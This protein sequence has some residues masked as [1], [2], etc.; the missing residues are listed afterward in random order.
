[1]KNLISLILFCGLHFCLNA[2]LNLQQE[3][4]KQIIS[5]DYDTS[6]IKEEDIDD[7][8]LSYAWYFLWKSKV[9]KD[10][11]V[12]INEIKDILSVFE[13]HE[14]K[15]GQ[16]LALMQVGVLYWK[17]GDLK[18]STEAYSETI[19]Y[20]LKQ[21]TVFEKDFFF[22]KITQART[23]RVT[24]FLE[25]KQ[26]DK[27][28]EDVFETEKLLEQI[29]TPLL[30]IN[31]LKN[32]AQLNSMLRNHKESIRI[33]NE[34]I[35]IGKKENMP[36]AVSIGLGNLAG[37]KAKLGKLDSAA[38]YLEKAL[39]HDKEHN[40]TRG[41]ITKQINLG[42]LLKYQK[43]YEEAE[44]FLD[45]AIEMAKVEQNSALLMQALAR[46]ASL[47]T[48]TNRFEESIE[49]N[50]SVIDYLEN[51]N[52]FDMVPL[53]YENLHESYLKLGKIDSALFVYKKKVKISD[54][55]SKV[56][57]ESKIQELN[58]KYQSEKKEKE[59]IKLKQET[60]EKDLSI[61]RKNNIIL[62]SSLIFGLVLI[63]LVTFQLKKFRDKNKALQFSIAQREKAEKEL[64][65]VR[66]NISKDFH[67]DLGNRL[68]RITSLSD[69]ILTTS[70]NRDK[71][72]VLSAIEKIKEDSDVL[73]NG[74]RDF[75][76]SLKANSDYAEE[77]FTYLSDFGE[78]FFQSFEIDFFVIKIMDRNVKLPYYWNR[79][80]IMIFKEAMTNI[81]KHAGSKKVELSMNLQK[82]KL[83]ISLSDNGEGFNIDNLK[84][85]N[86]LLNMKSRANKVG[87]IIDFE[88][89]QN[90]T[91]VIFTSFLPK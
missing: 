64:E 34:I 90:G 4:R 86:G 81:A 18:K 63:S 41:I 71:K 52:R 76:F 31:V 53:V 37:E 11:S 62:I 29:N 3:L 14:D 7:D 89:D 51:Q 25:L 61:S 88:S 68:A 58:I 24:N 73:Y 67:D 48:A 74:T 72:N 79:Q 87:A 55:I 16:A 23:Y 70:D 2:Q 40:L 35:A 26:L 69:L 82:D 83:Q 19:E 60:A 44:R 43:K 85:K 66:D 5:N 49:M 57:R 54:S 12:E 91:E 80:I 46:K 28:K 84:R 78:E 30:K 13:K 32:L 56:E 21:Q 50:K 45:E 65:T 33:N 15:E 59:N 17:S 6:K 9:Y 27:A 38:Y 8:D 39:K 36:K 75:M 20:L 42:N 22:T 10:I 47:L 77:L 1:M